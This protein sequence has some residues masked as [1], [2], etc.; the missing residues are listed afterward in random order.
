M[1]PSYHAFI[2]ELAL[3]KHA[4]EEKEKFKSQFMPMAKSRLGS[5]ARFGLGAGLGAGGGMLAGEA[6][7]KVWKTSTPGQRRVAGGAIGGMGV[8]GAMALWD[9][10]R[11]AEKRED[12]AAK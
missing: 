1:I 7:R 12:D 2:D 11:T 9:A 8:L 3:I 5:M 6:L 4:E 10:M